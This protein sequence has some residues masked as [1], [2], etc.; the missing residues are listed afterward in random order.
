MVQTRFDYQ[1]VMPT[2]RATHSLLN[3]G[4]LLGFKL[5]ALLAQEDERIRN[6]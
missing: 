5:A 1:F 6:G 4:A 3:S 2:H